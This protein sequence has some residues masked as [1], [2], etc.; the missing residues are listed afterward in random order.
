MENDLYHYKLGRLDSE[1]NSELATQA[2][3]RGIESTLKHQ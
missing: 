2:E 1:V 3:G